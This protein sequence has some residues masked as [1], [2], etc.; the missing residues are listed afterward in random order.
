M[1]SPVRQFNAERDHERLLDIVRALV[2][3]LGHH[4]ALA[5]VSPAAQLDR[6]LGLGSLERVELLVRLEAAFGSRL[7]ER[8][9]SEAETVQDLISALEAAN[10]QSLREGVV[11]IGAATGSK[12]EF[13]TTTHA[14]GF[15]SMQGAETFQ[16][17]LRLRGRS[18]EGASQT[19][20]LYTSDAADE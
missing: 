6:E 9:L 1:A 19:C 2:S 13:H 7:D 10:G 14:H 16:D 20:L 18:T 3:E 12:T 11:G 15:P 8:V 17:V 4:A 5:S